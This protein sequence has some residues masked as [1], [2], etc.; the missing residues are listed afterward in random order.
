MQVTTSDIHEGVIYSCLVLST[1]SNYREIQKYIFIIY[2]DNFFLLKGLQKNI[3]SAHNSVYTCTAFCTVLY[4]SFF[5]TELYNHKSKI[6]SVVMVQIPSTSLAS[7]ELGLTFVY[8]AILMLLIFGIFNALIIS[9][10]FVIFVKFVVFVVLK[11]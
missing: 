7:V 11:F 4:S 6:L 10:I 3:G 2:C 1:L 9:V 8:L 5:S